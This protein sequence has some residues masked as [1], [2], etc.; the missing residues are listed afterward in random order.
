M[1]NG[2]SAACDDRFATRALAAVVG[3]EGGSR[4]FWDLIDTGK[5]EVAT[6]WPQEFMDNGAWF[7]YLVC[8]PADVKTNTKLIEDVMDQVVQDGIKKEELD[9]AINKATAGCIMQSERPSNRLFGLGSR[10]LTHREYFST[11]DMLERL[12]SL[13]VDAVS[14]AAKKYCGG[15]SIEILA[16]KS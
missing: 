7:T 2:P 6:V 11:D 12:K 10:W 15:E 13:D 9:Q 8:D 16:A 4:L 5:A 3:D 14:A 1:T